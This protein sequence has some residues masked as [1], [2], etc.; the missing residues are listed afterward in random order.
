MSE[1]ITIENENKIAIKGVKK[2]NSCTPTNCVL[3]AESTIMISGNGLEVL[4]L[5]IDN[6]EV[7]L[8]GN[9]F[10][11]KFVQKGPKQPFL[12]RIFK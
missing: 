1:Y 8:Q 11:V 10:G 5:D 6:E 7:I 3:E 4:K 2:V 12:K 9:L